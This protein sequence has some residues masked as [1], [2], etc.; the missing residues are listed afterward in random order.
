MATV[1]FSET[2]VSSYEATLRHNPEEQQRHPHRHDNLKYH[3][4]AGTLM[5]AGI[6]LAIPVLDNQRYDN[7]ILYSLTVR[8][9]KQ[10]TRTEQQL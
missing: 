8:S 4:S 2:L 3:S 7:E 5:L 9:R 10:P 6:R 1:C